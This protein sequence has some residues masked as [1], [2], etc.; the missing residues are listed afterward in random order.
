VV[1]EE[2]QIRMPESLRID[3]ETEGR[4]GP[5]SQY[6][7]AVAGP[8]KVNHHNQNNGVKQRLMLANCLV[9][10]RV[11]QGKQIAQACTMTDCLVPTSSR[12]S[13]ICRRRGH[14]WHFACLLLLEVRWVLPFLQPIIAAGFQV[15]MFRVGRT[16]R[17]CKRF[18]VQAS[19]CDCGV[20]GC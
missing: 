6:N 8:P 13:E 7:P 3:K 17:M 20:R 19:Y 11:S 18:A 9:L 5:T 16:R 14:V 2:K 10:G 1:P 15:K 12:R 4:T